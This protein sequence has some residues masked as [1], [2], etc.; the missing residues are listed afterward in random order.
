MPLRVFN[1][2]GRKLEEFGTRKRHRVR[3]ANKRL[4]YAME[5]VGQL[6]LPGEAPARETT[7]NLLRKVQKSLGQLNDDARRHALQPIVG[8]DLR[9][10]TGVQDFVG[11]AP[12]NLVYVADFGKMGD[13]SAEERTF[14]ASADA[15]FP[16]QNVY[17]FCAAAGLACVVRGLVDRRKL[18]PLLQLRPDQR[19]VLAQTVGY[20]K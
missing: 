2:L 15:A 16:A 10:A 5:A 9:A 6:V 1:T 3:L 20:P 19:I 4:S 13:A 11:T 7:L 12:L 8:A 17:L 14:Y 18:A